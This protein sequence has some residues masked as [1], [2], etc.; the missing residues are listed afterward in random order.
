LRRPPCSTLSPYT[1]LFRSPPFAQ[2][3]RGSPH[4][5]RMGLAW[6]LWSVRGTALTRLTGKRRPLSSRPGRR[7]D[8]TPP[9]SRRVQEVRPPRLDRKST[10]L[11]S[12][13][14]VISYA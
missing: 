3:L 1:T 11:N 4:A 7:D 10:R 6:P 2:A 13:H 8:A 14:L 12:S 5:T 9:I